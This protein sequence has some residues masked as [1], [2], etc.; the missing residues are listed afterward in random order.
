LDALTLLKVAV[1]SVRP[2]LTAVTTPP[3]L[4][5]AT[6]WLVDD[7]LASIVRS[8]T[9]PSE[10][11]TIA[12]SVPRSPLALSVV[13]PLMASPMAL[14][15]AGAVVVAVVDGAV[16]PDMAAPH[17]AVKSTETSKTP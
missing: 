2:S 15:L 8:T 4:T 10:Y 9:L 3:A 7:Q 14:A 16:G 5:V 6:A 13:N 17:A 1:T 11:V 12:A